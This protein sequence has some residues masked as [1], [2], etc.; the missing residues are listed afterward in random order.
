MCNAKSHDIIAYSIFSPQLIG[1]DE[2]LK[3]INALI[4]DGLKN[5]GFSEKT[6]LEGL[7]CDFKIKLKLMIFFKC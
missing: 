4:Q 6:T 2:C 7:V 3:I 5:A 1:I